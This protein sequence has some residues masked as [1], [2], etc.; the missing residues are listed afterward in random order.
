M[1]IISNFAVVQIYNNFKVMVKN[2]VKP[3][4]QVVLPHLKEGLALQAGGSGG[5]N[6]DEQLSKR[7]SFFDD[8]DTDYKSPWDT[9]DNK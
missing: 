5:A 9:Q 6:E 4:C 8:D 1:E 3:D 2:Y 7:N